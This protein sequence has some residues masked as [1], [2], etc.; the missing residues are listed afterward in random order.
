[1]SF[2]T[3]KASVENIFCYGVPGV[4]IF[5]MKIDNWPPLESWK[6]FLASFIIGT[7]SGLASGIYLDKI[8]T[9]GKWTGLHGKIKS[10]LGLKEL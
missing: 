3:I 6:Y 4:T 2:E 10:L 5:G 9:D 8:K 1:M 7:I